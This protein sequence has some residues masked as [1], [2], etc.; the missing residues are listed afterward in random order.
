MPIYQKLDTSAPAKGRKTQP[1]L[2]R[3]LRIDQP[4]Q[5]WCTR[6]HEYEPGQPV[7]VLCMDD[8]LRRALWR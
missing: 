6:D 4:N 7:H 1:Y 5:G 8:T 3:G 2:L